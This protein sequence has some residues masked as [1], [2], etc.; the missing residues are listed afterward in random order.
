M[1]PQ[2]EYPEKVYTTKSGLL[3]S[4]DMALLQQL[5]INKI[6][7]QLESTTNPKKIKLRATTP[8]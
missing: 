6:T 1:K 2:L 5:G 7:E 8:T 3:K 4:S